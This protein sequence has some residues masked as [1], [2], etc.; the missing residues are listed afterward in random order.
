MQRDLGDFQ[1][2][3]ELAAAIVRALRTERTRW[4]RVLEPTCGTGSFLR[5]ALEAAHPPLEMIGVEIQNDHCGAARSLSGGRSGTRIDVIHSNLFDLD[6]RRDL[7]WHSAGPLLVVGNPPWITSAELGRLE[8][9]NVPGKSNIKRFKGLDA[10]TGASNFD[11]AEA[12]WLKLLAELAAEEPTIAL[13]CKRAVARAVLEEARR[14]G[15]PI[16]GAEMYEIDAA[17]WFGAAVGACLLRIDVGRTSS[18]RTIPVFADID[19]PAPMRLM[20]FHQGR[21]VA[22]HAAIE[23]LSFALGTCPLVWRQ[24]VKHDAADVM[25]LVAKDDNGQSAWYNKLGYKVET[26]PEYVYPFLKGADLRRPPA[27]RPRRALIVTHERIGQDTSVL[28]RRAPRLWD[29]LLRYRHILDS[30]KSS[31]YR[32]QP[33]FALFGIGPYSF[34]PYK[35][36]V[37]GLHRPARFQALGPIDG[38]PV[39]VDDTCYLLPCQTAAEA[40][41]LTA[42]C[43]GPIVRDLLGALS[44]GD[45]KRPV[46]KALLQRIDLSEILS[47]EDPRDLAARARAVLADHLGVRSDAT[48][49]LAAEIERLNDRFQA[50]TRPQPHQEKQHGVRAGQLL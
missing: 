38:R 47:R 43:D 35:V 9:G 8:S 7:S 28:E 39:M 12:V 49:P 15:L 20:G 3:P 5:A 48:D 22:D 37:S 50:E 10:L 36:A 44:F 24:G 11:V 27:A 25:E 14:L 6:L 13:L 33:R 31:I 41:L 23:R 32:G 1:T 2:P 46:T 16:A 30:R 17:R 29:Y 18:M 4:T 34:A 19:Q 26:E 42:L 21:L 40:A 45:A